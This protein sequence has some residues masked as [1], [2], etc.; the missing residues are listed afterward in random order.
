M[1]NIIIDKQGRP[2]KSSIFLGNQH[3]NLDETLQ[4]F[5]SKEY[6]DH[7]RYIAYCYKDRRTGKKI[8]GI[9]PLVED[10]FK[11]T[12]A[13]T[14]CAGMWQLYV[15]C[16]T[17]QID[18]TATLIDLTAN[19]STSEH[20]FISD[21]INGR[22]S[23]N[24]IDIEAFEN[25]AV[26][27][28]IKILY[29]DILSLKLRVE[30]NEA[31]RQSQE[32]VRQTAEANRANAESQRVSA[33]QS[34]VDSEGLRTQSEE[35]RSQSET[36]RT[37]AEN[38]RDE[39]ERIRQSS[40]ASRATAES[41]RVET[42]KARVS[43]EASRGTEENKRVDAENLRKQNENARVQAETLRN[44]SETARVES[45][46][47]RV[48]AENARVQAEQSRV[49]VESQRV[50]AESNRS[51]AERQRVENET[52]RINAE[53][54]RADAESLRVTAESKRA[55]DTAASLKKIDDTVKKYSYIDECID[56][57]K[58]MG[59]TVVDGCLCMYDDN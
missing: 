6:E 3:E 40:E 19:N 4:F 34:R 44:Q 52:G 39:A 32:S 56:L 11:V 38:E 1:I 15:I 21:A 48:N 9:S 10:A 42:E 5:F 47:T 54:S 33:E 29:D 41:K 27:E 50:S 2:S 24:E 16:K 57:Q 20:I 31:T 53:Q 14:K 43:T 37:N 59:I 8:T 28:N 23:G 58:A 13:I 46:K 7:Y 35:S 26:D 17:T 49:S 51:S 55:T 12:S 22:I 36:S 18:E 25:I 45:E 30:K